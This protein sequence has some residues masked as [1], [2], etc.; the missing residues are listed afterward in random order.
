MED[1]VEYY[2][3]FC[4]TGCNEWVCHMCNDY[5]GIVKVGPTQTMREL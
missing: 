1:N 3:T 2:C 5:K 4:S